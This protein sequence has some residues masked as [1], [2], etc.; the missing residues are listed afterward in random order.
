VD[1]GTAILKSSKNPPVGLS[2][3][4]TVEDDIPNDYYLYLTGYAAKVLRKELPMRDS[5][6]PPVKK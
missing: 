5:V 1:E 4:V 3:F 2:S 6:P